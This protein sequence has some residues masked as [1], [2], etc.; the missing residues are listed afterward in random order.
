MF[1]QNNEAGYELTSVLHLQR[2]AD[3]FVCSPRAWTAVALRIAGTTVFESNGQTLC[4]G[5]GSVVY[6]PSG[7]RYRR[8]STQEELMILHLHCHGTEETEIQLWQPGA[9]VQVSGFF[10]EM[11]DVWKQR[12]PGYRHRCLA[13]FYELLAQM[14]ASAS[15]A[16]PRERLI[17]NSLTY[18]S[19]HFDNPQLRMNEVARQSNIS[20]VYFRRLHRELF[21]CPPSEALQRMR[22]ERAA[23]LLQSGYCNVSEAAE[24]AGFENSKYFSTLFKQKMGCTPSEYRKG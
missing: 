16:A 20:E 2:R 13:L 7:V 18:M 23:Q 11:A 10:F 9:S 17:Q 12:A 19:L 4:A 14:E 8:A 6:I 5:P 21:G 15:T 24:K 3:E 22:L 1:Y